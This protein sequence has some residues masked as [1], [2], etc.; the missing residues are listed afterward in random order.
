MVRR[1][2]RAS[3]AGRA[4]ACPLFTAAIAVFAVV[5]TSVSAG[6][7][8]SPG[9]GLDANPART[10]PSP[11]AERDDLKRKAG[12]IYFWGHLGNPIG[13][14]VHGLPNPFVIR[15]SELVIF[16]D[17]QWVIEKL[18]WTHWGS[19]VAQAKGL[20]SSSDDNPNAVEGKRIITSAKVTLYDPGVFHG[21]KVYRCIR[22]KVP[23]PAH[24]GT[25]CLQRVGS[26]VVLGSPGSGTPVGG[27]ETGGSRHLTNFL[28]PDKKVWCLIDEEAGVCGVG[29]QRGGTAQLAGTISKSGKVTTCAVAVPSLAE[30]CLMNWDSSAPVLH[31]GE[32]TQANGIRCTSAKSGITCVKVSGAGEGKGFRVNRDEAV[33]VG[34]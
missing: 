16:E 27:E 10:P 29:G 33:E 2:K 19:P 28:S 15:P 34:S 3:S 18:H 32:R 14:P 1:R 4:F 17:G 12:P 13:S 8:V 5:P 9:S 11:I 7:S 30:V 26:I 24:Y 22:I 20:S 23:P 25:S 6:S 21:K 31:Y